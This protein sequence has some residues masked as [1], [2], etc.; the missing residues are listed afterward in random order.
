MRLVLDV[1][2]VRDVALPLPG[3]AKHWLPSEAR[4]DGMP[5]YIRR[6]DA[7][8]G[9]PWLLVSAGRHRVELAGALTTRDR[10]QL[11]LP[12]KPRRVE[13]QAEGWEVAG[14]SEESGV[15]DTLQLS[16]GGREVRPDEAREK[17]KGK[18]ETP[19]L[20]PFLRVERRLVL[21][22]LWRVETTV[23]RDSP[24]GVPVVVQIPLLP[25]EA[26]TTSG[27][28]VEDGKALVNLGPQSESLRWS[29]TLT[30]REA[31]TLSALK[32]DAWVESWSI[33][34]SSLW[35]IEAQGIPP[36]AATGGDDLTFRPW[37]GETLQLAITRPQPVAGQTLTIDQSTL[38]VTAGER[39]SDYRLNLVLRSSRG[40]DHALMLPEGAVL[41]RVAIN[42]KTLPI[43]PDGDGRRLM[44]PVTPGKQTVEI[45]WRSDQEMSMN[46][47]THS[48][49][50]GQDSVN[51]RIQLTL[52]HDRWLLVA[53]GPGIGPAILF[54]GK[55]LVLIAVA[56]AI[57][58]F[59]ARQAAWP[60]RKAWQWLL[61]ALG[62]TQ[63]PWWS[64]AFVV[65]WF[66]AFAW[67]E[68]QRAADAVPVAAPP[69]GRLAALSHWPF[70]LAQILL[71]LLTLLML[72][73]LFSAVESGL[74]GY[75]DMQV[76]G[77]DSSAFQ[78]KWYLDRAAATPLGV[79]VLSLP[80]LVYRG[81]MLLW[82]LWLAWS[83]LDW[84][85]WGWNAF[86]AGGLWRRRRK[87]QE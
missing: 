21:D 43:R 13:V 44:L 4:L 73:V 6:D 30:Q 33:S 9:D 3:G 78:L 37:P 67:R 23:Y 32:T 39:A 22:L 5:A 50:L 36:I 84:L 11:P 29:S 31:L 60:M 79:W 53:G 14:L 12:L 26:V 10:V 38:E 7:G 83:L 80:I 54:W 85:K 49:G 81:L 52:P 59:S 45:V 18:N 51:H 28:V 8:D 63:A 72:G 70:N 58:R 2:A 34:A 1:E 77:N 20:P 35:H 71:V 41:Q 40:A 15:A 86:S 27:I 17:D 42:G 68:R 87:I 16:R 55:L 25:G 75:P 64:A 65:A 76:T 47:V 48:A 82:A 46:Y 61:L 56:V 66:A 74:L 24:V 19:A 62:L 57:G 69:G